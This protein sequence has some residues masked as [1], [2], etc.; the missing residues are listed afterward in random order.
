MPKEGKIAENGTEK[1]STGAVAAETADGGTDGSD[2]AGKT[3]N[4]HDKGYK[5]V[6]KNRRVLLHMLRKY[7]DFEWAWDVREEDIEFEDKEFVTDY[8]HTYESDLISKIR[9]G[10]QE[11]YLF[12]LLELQS[13]MDFTMPFRLLVYMVNIWEQYFRNVPEDKRELK[14]FRLPMVVP[15]VLYNG[16]ESWTALRRFR[17]YLRDGDMFGEYGVNFEYALI[18]V[19]RLAKDLI[20]QSNSVIDNIFYMDSAREKADFLSAVGL[21]MDRVPELPADEKNLLETWFEHALEGMFREEEQAFIRECFR[22]GEK[23]MIS[24]F[25]QIVIAERENA[26]QEGIGIG[27]DR[28]I[29]QGTELKL[30]N[31]VLKKM[32]KSCTVAQIAEA[33]EESEEKIGRIVEIARK[34]APEYD[35]RKILDEIMSHPKIL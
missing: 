11:I 9:L 1:I 33:L 24:G 16:R 31:L 28:G 12:L 21:V 34:Y 29:E 13:G 25:E 5:R 20:L 19:R 32:R 8:F 30:I 7:T 10:E 2:D 15:M 4:P 27:V 35:E 23:K 18:D 22:K 17:D 14:E 6:L 26:K 3:S